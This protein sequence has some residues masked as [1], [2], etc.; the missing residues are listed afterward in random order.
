MR[1]VRNT[2]ST[3]L[4][5][6]MNMPT[7]ATRAPDARQL[8]DAAADRFV[9]QQLLIHGMGQG[10]TDSGASPAFEWLAQG[11]ESLRREGPPPGWAEEWFAGTAERPDWQDDARLANGQRCF[12][13]WCLPIS[14][15][16]FCASLPKAYAA[17]YGVQTLARMSQLNDERQ[18][19]TRI[20]NTGRML[21]EVT[22]TGELGP[23]GRGY[24]RLRRV[25]LLHALCRALVLA[26]PTRPWSPEWGV[27][28]NQEDQLGTLLSF[29]VTVQ[30]ALHSL[31]L[32]TDEADFDDYLHLWS[33][34]GWHL[35]TDDAHLLDSLT[36]GIELQDGLE[37]HV[38]GSTPEGIRLMSLL[39]DD[40]CASMPVW[41]RGLPPA[42]VQ[43]MAGSPVAELLHVPV[44]PAPACRHPPRRR[45]RSPPRPGQPHRPAPPPQPRAAHLRDDAAR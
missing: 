15:A 23:G 30:Q 18:V 6:D 29:S 25:R 4:V 12:T 24:I 16:L 1:T 31:G 45:D 17:R 39:I 7:A 37:A 22:K 10:V 27:P 9:E 42:L 2:R 33:V 19:S 36:R 3:R 44:S 21:L 11:V 13:K 35:G 41:M 14:I 38:F 34:V 43:R 8:G 5:S 26:D 20:G 32:R 40:M 28:V